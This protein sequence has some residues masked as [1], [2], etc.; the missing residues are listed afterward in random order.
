MLKDLS[1]FASIPTPLLDQIENQA[2]KTTLD[3]GEF[4]FQENSPANEM[5][6]ILSGTVE[7]YKE[8]EGQNQ[9]IATLTA[10]DF[11]G[12]TALVTNNPRNATIITL[13]TVELLVI[14]RQLFDQVFGTEPTLTTHISEAI[15][16]RLSD[17]DLTRIQAQRNKYE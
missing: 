7:V 12:E 11:F 17:N 15:T 5:Y 3:S 10:G 1:I 16:Q 8:I 13:T 4:I 9:K 2:Q 14:T 6:L